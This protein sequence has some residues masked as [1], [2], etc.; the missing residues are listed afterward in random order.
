MLEQQTDQSA[1]ETELP[2]QVMASLIE[3]AKQAYENAHA[4][5]SNFHVG[6]AAVS[7]T[8]QIYAGCNVENATYGLTVCA[9]RN[10]VGNAV[11]RGDKQ[12]SAIVIFTKEERLTP[13]CGACRQVICEFFPSDASVIATNHLGQQKRWTVEQLLPDAFT[14]EFL[15]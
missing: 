10:A 1:P 4:P 9:E 5:Y 13:P 11:T 3:Q 8:G 14:P 2:T 6:A 15:L 7:K 12:L